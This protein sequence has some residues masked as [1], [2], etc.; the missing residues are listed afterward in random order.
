MVNTQWV[1]QGDVLLQLL[2]LNS[3]EGDTCPTA[4]PVLL[5][6]EATGHAHR[7]RE[8]IEV[9]DILVRYNS[10]T[11]IK[12]FRLPRPDVLEHEEHGPIPL[13]AGDVRAYRKR[14]FDP[15]VAN[16]ADQ[17]RMVRD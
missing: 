5:E 12:A 9:E 14:E 16:P 3:I 11:F 6:G 13:P 1:R 15:F 7:L 10:P 4:S 17:V 2:P 8:C